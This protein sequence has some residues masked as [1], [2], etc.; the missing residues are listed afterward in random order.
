MLM[1]RLGAG[2]LSMTLAAASV[3][4]TD[5]PTLLT[6]FN[7]TSWT[8]KDGLGSALIWSVVQD[9]VGY[10]WLG[11][12]SGAL[13]FDGVRFVPWERLAHIPTPAVSVRTIC[14][15][16]DGTLWFG[17]G[18]P[19][20]IVA[21]R[22]GQART[23]GVE[24]GLSEGVVT[25]IA[26]EP[27]GTL[28]AGGRFG[29][30]RL[31]SD[32]WQPADP[33]LPAGL[34]NELLVADN[35]VI[36]A[37]A[38]G[39]Y[40]RRPREEAFS[41]LG[42]FRD[43]ARS[44]VRDHSGRLWIADPISGAR[45]VDDRAGL[46][47]L[48][49][50]GRGS[51]LLHDS[52]GNLW[53]GTGGQGLWRVRPDEAMSPRVWERTSTATGLSDDGVTEIREDRDGNIWVATRDGLNRL[54]PHKMTPITDVGIV[55]AV[56]VTRDGRVW[57]GAVDAIVPFANGRVG[58]R[59]A[60]IPL[61]SPPLA[62]MQA[63]A[64]GTLWVATA[65]A[66]MRVTGGRLE[67]VPLG[68]VP[69]TALTDLT[70]DG[71]DGLW[72]HDTARGLLHWRAGVLT[73][74]ALPAE[75]GSSAV[76]ASLTDREGHAWFTFER[77]AVARIDAFGAVQVYDE[78]RG[79]TAGPYRAVHQD[80]TGTVW[81]GGDRGL[82][83]FAAGTFTTL[84]TTA[85][86]PIRRVTGIVDD[87]RGALWLAIEGEGLL[88]L[89]R[90]EIAR[91]LADAA[92]PM[93][94]AAYDKV[95]GSAGTSRWFGSKA[96]A[97]SMN[98][99]LWFVAGRGVTVVDPEALAVDRPADDTVHIEGA[100]IDG[101]PISAESAQTLRPGTARVQIDFTVPDLTSPQKHRFRY[102][103]DGF[104]AGWVD[105]GRRHSAFYTNLPPR[106]Y[107]FHVEATNADGSFPGT[108]GTWA[109]VIRPAFYQTW[110]FATIVVATIAFVIGAAWRL[111]VLRMRRQFSLL[112]GE[113]ARLSREVHDTLLQSMFGY[114]LQVDGL[115]EAVSSSHPQ[116]R[117]RLARLRLQVEE[118][119][120]EARQSIWNLRSPRLDERDLPAN[121]KQTVDQAIASTNLELSFEVKGEAH[122]APSQ[123]E[124]Q[125]LR[126]G[127]EAVSNVVRHA[128]ASRV[129][130][131]L[132]YGVRDITLSVSD[133]GL[134]FELGARPQPR[135]HFGLTTM[136][137][138]AESAGGSLR[139]HTEP[140]AGTTVTVC[141]PAA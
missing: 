10:L 139:I 13:R 105:A 118:D 26:Q 138:R 127:R 71:R 116:L 129:R 16:S 83:R 121:L 31:V 112:V 106:P 115:A 93:R 38:G 113:R 111:H 98:G 82:T 47:L 43:N 119:I 18:E 15:A 57:V 120:R 125:L 108:P 132:D 91:V 76:L 122:R 126:I 90:D 96:A 117:E 55:T 67:P 42:G 61:P 78:S 104:D 101:Q 54:T 110:W 100:V 81:F 23:Y 58:A 6:G 32:R 130:V 95:D 7:L 63:D 36:V 103:L 97:R 4:A 60:P 37:T 25:T 48:G 66:L 85:T 64:G 19:G 114:A 74:A 12:D 52:H 140:G 72:L 1:S 62:A 50:K 68:G 9:D 39:V 27:N 136:R 2:A 41:Q 56:D 51:R 92:H 46:V 124:E 8:Q 86:M 137:E 135:E 45:S 77:G 133:D 17:L 24:D 134:G 40:R 59:A 70:S 123:V 49:L 44:V 29:L 109:F 141:T 69:L 87:G 5:P 30:R 53:V 107:T 84:S 80:L 22:N 131:L 89:S 28:W 88:R 75:V 99:Q 94:Y 14:V 102:R 65:K 35:A 34:V 128:R 11:T 21:L 79:L 73:P 20:G 33:G 3:T